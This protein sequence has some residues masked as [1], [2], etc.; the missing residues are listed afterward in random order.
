MLYM[1]SY[2]SF[3]VREYSLEEM[4]VMLKDF[5]AKNQRLGITGLLVYERKMFCQFIEGE[6]ATVRELF[7]EIRIDK[8][9]RLPNACSETPIRQR[10]FPDWHMAFE[11][12]TSVQNCSPAELPRPYRDVLRFAFVRKATRPSLSR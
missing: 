10:A 7:E 1:L 12:L 11:G 5:R 8:R 3:A 9:H 6:E 4:D 2:V